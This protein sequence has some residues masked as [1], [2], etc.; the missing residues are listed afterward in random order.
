M[1]APEIDDLTFYKGTC[2]KLR[3]DL[4]R[5]NGELRKAKEIM[6]YTM[7]EIDA[8]W[9]ANTISEELVQCANNIEEFLEGE[10]DD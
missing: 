2:D 9:D 1:I 6:K 10:C 7:E 5:V 8:A 3:I 4:D